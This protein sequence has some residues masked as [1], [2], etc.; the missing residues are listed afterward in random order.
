[1]DEIMKRQEELQ[2]LKK[3]MIKCKPSQ[4][5]A[6]HILAYFPKAHYDPKMIDEHCDYIMKYFS[7]RLDTAVEMLY[8]RRNDLIEHEIDECIQNEKKL[9][10][11][12]THDMFI[13]LLTYGS[14]K[15]N[16]GFKTAKDLMLYLAEKNV[17]LTKRDHKEYT[18]DQVAQIYLNGD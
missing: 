3:G 16:A 6:C 10:L 14:L 15:T 7:T 18:F 2:E 1:M 11:A 12:F 4:K 5:Q 9:M 8:V 17:Y 13:K